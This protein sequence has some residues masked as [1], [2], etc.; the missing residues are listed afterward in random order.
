LPPSNIRIET[1]QPLFNK[2]NIMQTLH[3]NLAVS[4]SEFQQNPLTALEQ[5]EPV[6][7]LAENRATAYLLPAEFYETLMDALDDLALAELVQQRQGQ[8]RIK[9]N[10]DE[11]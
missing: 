9:V 8:E 2:G 11:L 4:L 1:I 10:F 3:A 5:S 7:I 6:A